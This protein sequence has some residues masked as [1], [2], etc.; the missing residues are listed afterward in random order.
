MR[1]APR[2]RLLGFAVL[3]IFLFLTTSSLLLAQAPGDRPVRYPL[4]PDASVRNVILFIGDGMGLAHLE[5]SRMDT[6]G[7]N[8]WYTIE[9]MPVTTLVRTNSADNI[10]TDSAA[11]AT[12]YATG[13]KTNNGML[14]VSP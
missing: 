6:E 2:P 14:S 10:V 11:G 9:C 13:H 1:V 4:M 8:G 12:A 5:A 7:A 3:V